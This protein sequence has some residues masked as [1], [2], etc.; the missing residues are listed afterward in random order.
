MNQRSLAVLI[1]L[2]AVLLSAIAL[3][4]GP[5]P[6]AEAQIGG[7]SFLMISGDTAQAQ[8]QVIYVMDTSTGNLAGFTVN[9][10]N[11]KVEVIG[12]RKVADDL[13][14]GLGGDR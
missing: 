12:G 10:A 5:V 1:V 3:T 7:G 8:Q 4:V 2:N 13:R 14:K 11:K 6:R 9:S